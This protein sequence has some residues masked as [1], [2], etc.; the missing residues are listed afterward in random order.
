M[1]FLFEDT[2]ERTAEEQEELYEAL[3]E[4][5]LSGEHTAF[6]FIRNT[7]E[8]GVLCKA[9]SGLNKV[10]ELYELIRRNIYKTYCKQ[11]LVGEQDFN[12]I[13]ALRQIM[14]CKTFYEDE[15]LIIKDMLSEYDAYLGSG[16]F[17][18][19]FLFG[20]D[21]ETWHMWDHRREGPNGNFGQ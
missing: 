3:T 2:S 6:E 17:M 21:R 15:L 19:Q 11:I 10:I 14:E 18:Q 7:A 16:H 5:A 12:L 13:Y 8:W 9:K 4:K 20:M 1:N